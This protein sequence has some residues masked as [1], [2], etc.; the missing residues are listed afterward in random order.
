MLCTGL[1][2]L[3]LC[4]PL[5]GT[6]RTDLETGGWGPITSGTRPGAWWVN[7]V[8]KS[9]PAAFSVLVSG[10]DKNVR[11][12]LVK[13]TDFSVA[14]VE[15]FLGSGCGPASAP[16]ACTIKKAQLRKRQCWQG[17]LL[18]ARGEP[19]TPLEDFVCDGKSDRLGSDSFSFEGVSGSPASTQDGGAFREY[20]PQPPASPR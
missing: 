20:F 12:V 19:Q 8:F 4:L 15:Q 6:L 3:G 2:I 16:A 17:I 18:A 10:Q 11:A 7:K 5:P 14:E 13:S 9:G 1:T